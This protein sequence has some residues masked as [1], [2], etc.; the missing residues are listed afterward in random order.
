MNYL[1]FFCMGDWCIFHYLPIYSICQL[2]ETMEDHT[3]E[4]LIH[5][6]ETLDDSSPFKLLY[7]VVQT[8]SELGFHSVLG[9]A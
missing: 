5:Q 2:T 3:R 4:D 6:I 1:E 7:Q 8:R 9:T